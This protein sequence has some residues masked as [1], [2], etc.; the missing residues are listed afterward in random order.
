[1][2]LL[3]DKPPKELK[4]LADSVISNAESRMN[5]APKKSFVEEVMPL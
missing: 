1:M 2:S 4:S 3:Q 5:R